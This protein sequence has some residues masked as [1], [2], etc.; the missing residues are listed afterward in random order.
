MI[1]AEP[2]TL[3]SSLNLL[4]VVLDFPED[5][6]DLSS[7]PLTTDVQRSTLAFFKSR[8]AVAT[9]GWINE[10]DAMY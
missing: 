1:A 6:L 9:P 8:L 5:E 4:T 7:R 2:M 3:T 10:T